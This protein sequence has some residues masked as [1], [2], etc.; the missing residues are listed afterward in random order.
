MFH[1][2]HTQAS[3]QHTLATWKW[4]IPYSRRLLWTQNDCDMSDK[5]NWDWVDVI[6]VGELNRRIISLQSGEWESES[7]WIVQVVVAW[8]LESCDWR[9]LVRSSKLPF[10][11]F[12]SNVVDVFN[13]PLLSSW[14]NQNTQYL[15][16]YR[17]VN[18]L[19]FVSVAKYQKLSLLI[20][21]HGYYPMY[22]HSKVHILRNKDEE[23]NNI[24]GLEAKHE[25]L[26]VSHH[27]RNL[28]ISIFYSYVVQ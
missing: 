5:M 20:N 25:L 14:K 8:W 12:I 1:Q 17:V 24:N 13:N 9:W 15:D 22:R 26:Q 3:Y 2:V 4:A 19:H 23:D 11:M 6:E 18:I 21:K 28:Y 27:Q 10:S 7:R 16:M